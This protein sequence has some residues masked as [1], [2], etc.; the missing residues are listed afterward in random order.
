MESKQVPEV[1][2]DSDEIISFKI[3][4]TH[5]VWLGYIDLETYEKGQK[6]FLD[7]FSL[8]PSKDWL[9][10]FGHGHI[11]IEI[12]GII[13]KYEIKKNVRF[14]YKNRELKEVNYEEFKS[15]N[16]GSGW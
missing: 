1:K 10:A 2:K 4:P 12:N 11:S 3:I 5:E 15:L 16:R 6:I 7:E 14:L 8:D 9:L 13:K